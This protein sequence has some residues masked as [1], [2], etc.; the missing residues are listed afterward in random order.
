LLAEAFKTMALFGYVSIWTREMDMK[1]R[2]EIAKAN[3]KYGFTMVELLTVIMVMAILAGI[4]LG[5][6]GYASRKAD[7]SKAKADLNLL[8]GA[9]EEHKAERGYYPTGFTGHINTNAPGAITFRAAIS[10]YYPEAVWTDPWGTG[11]F[12]QS[13]TPHQYKLW[14]YGPNR[15]SNNA[16][17]RV[18][19]ITGL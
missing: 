6:A 8:R 17:N 5:G 15:L 18:D 9:L 12:Y 4:I 16:S 7:E 11:Y 14:S 2:A 19:D 3:G 13:L 1:T 10:N